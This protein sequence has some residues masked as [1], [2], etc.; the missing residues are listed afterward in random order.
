MEGLSLIQP[1]N[2]LE[3]TMVLIFS[4]KLMAFCYGDTVPLFSEWYRFMM[5]S[6]KIT[7]KHTNFGTFHPFHFLRGQKT[8]MPISILNLF[9]SGLGKLCQIHVGPI[10]LTTSFCVAHK[11]LNFKWLGLGGDKRRIWFPN[12]FRLHEIQISGPTSED[13][14]EHRHTHSFIQ[15][16]RLLS[17]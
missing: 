9:K 3:E 8:P 2:G 4:I 7:K 1:R 16:L 17:C 11:F 13:L 6:L 10:Q 5:I 15:C 12:T 14:L